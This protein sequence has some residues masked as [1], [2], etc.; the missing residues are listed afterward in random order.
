MLS[1]ELAGRCS[2]CPWIE[3]PY[4]QQIEE[5]QSRFAATA[6][7]RGWQWAEAPT[8]RSLAE[9]GLRDRV[10]LNFRAPHLGIYD[11]DRSG[12]VSMT[13]CP[14]M[15]PALQ[16]WFD[17]FRKDPPPI[18]KGTIRLRVAPG[19][20]RGA[21][22]DF[23]N[24]DV[25]RLLDERAWLER[26]ATKAIVEVG[27]R[28]KRLVA[29]EERLRL[30]EPR[31]HPWMKTAGGLDLYSVIGSFTQPGTAVN[32]LLVETV[33]STVKKTASQRW[34]ELGAGSG[35]FT[36]PLA[37]AGL[38]VVAV[39]MDPLAVLGLARGAE[40]LPPGRLRLE[41][42]NFDRTEAPYWPEG[43]GWGCLVDPPR[44]GLGR[45]L[46]ALTAL[47]PERRPDDLVYVSCWEESFWRDADRLR[48]LGYHPV[49]AQGIELFPQTPHLE[50]VVC[51]QRKPLPL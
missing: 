27:Q 45:W 49:S 41:R 36:L 44:S 23:A 26:L 16:N 40:S 4:D 35:N 43:E 24:E 31:L 3:R 28:K 38:E 20:D 5:K 42:A 11:V 22:L 6:A 51:F 12:L 46:E 8:V 14:Q 50:W 1:C 13:E 47:S 30:A 15:S 18:E 29:G 17:E 39:E 48:A 19:G 7:A 32:Q 2:G 9:G 37:A 10:D 33:L 21:W 34:V 25:K